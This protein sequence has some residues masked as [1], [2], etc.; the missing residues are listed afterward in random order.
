MASICKRF[1]LYALTILTL[2]FIGTSQSWAQYASGLEGTVV[3]QSG[4]VVTG[5]QCSVINQ[6]TGIRQSASSDTQGYVR[7]LKLP[8]GHYRIEIGAPGFEKWVQRDV[9]VEG[10][11]LRTFYPSLK[12]GQNFATVEVHGE[13]EAL[14]TAQGTVSRTL[15]QQTVSEAPLVGQ[16]VYASVASLA[17]GM[18]GLGDASGSIA[19]AGSQGTNSFVT[20]AGFQINAAG[21]RQDANEFQVDG[22]SVMSTSRDGVVNITPEPDTI[23][24][25]KL[26][27]STFNADEGRQSGA[28]IEVY[29]KPGTNNFHG[30]LSEMHTD[31]AMT[32]RTVFETQVPHSLRNDFGGTLGGPIFKNRTFFFGSLFWMRSLIG[33]TLNETVETQGFEQYVEQN[34]PNSMAAGF[35]KAAPPAA[36]PVKNFLTVA[37]VESQYGSTYAP[38]NIPA[39]MVAEGESIVNASPSNNGFQGHLRIDHNFRGDRD[40]LFYSLFRNTTQAENANIRTVYSY[41]SPDNSFYN[42]VDYLHTFSASLVNDVSAGFV[43]TSGS[44]PA[45][46]PSLPN[47]AWIGGIDATFWQWGPSGWV[48]NNWYAHD[49]LNYTRGAHTFRVGIDVDRQQDMDNFTNGDDRPYFLMLNVLDMA[50]DHPFEQSGPVLNPKTGQVATNLYQRVLLLYTAPY[51]EDDWKINHRLTL[52][53][54]IRFDYFGH[55]STMENGQSPVSF[56]TPGTGSDFA[57]QVANG[58]MVVRGNNGIATNHAQ[59]RFAPRLGFAW[60]VWGNGHTA[61]HGGYGLFNNK[62]GEYGY[63]NNM[64]ENPPN[65]VNPVVSIFTPGETLANMSYGTSSSGA[66]GFAPPPGITFQVD[67]HGGIVGSRISVGG[68]DPNLKSPLVHSWALGVQQKIGG[69]VAE[70]DYFGTA[71]RNLY[72]QTDVNRFA[73]DE[74]INNGNLD[75]LNQSFGEVLYGRNDGIANS[76]LVAFAISKHFSKGWNFHAIYT[77]GKSLDYTSDNDNGVDG[78][79]AEAVLD[80]QTLAGQYG[81]SDYDSRHR[82]SADAVWNAP[83]FHEGVAHA[84]TSGWT[85]T[86]VV[87]LQ[88][89]QPFTVYTG[90][91]Y[92]SGGDYN[93]DGWDFDVPNVPSFGNHISTSRSNFLKGLFPASAFPAPAAGTEGNLGRNTYDGPGFANVNLSAERSFN[94]PVLGDRGKLEL[95]GEFFNLFNR[96]NLTKPVSDL[97]NTLFGYSTSQDSPRFIQLTGHIRF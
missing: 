79:A 93:G 63:V 60:D 39:N 20:E 58:S 64:R 57:A 14:E 81:R 2:A 23:S 30:S 97:S 49:A 68:I 44:Q 32:A 89:G 11:E 19:S 13:N 38:P 86:P 65:D 75:R 43:R 50:A 40:K 95:R 12:I 7:F 88:S 70:G 90:A 25:M 5:A 54:G 45:P 24:E 74:I 55:L 31:A 67:S 61:I 82:F 85:F 84:I 94:L 48:Q 96:V 4:A 34:Y 17:P 1:T 53:A 47:V 80:A 27:S 15:E 87:I 92:S 77:F 8:P 41:L 91:Q 52:N 29:T 18:T 62:I 10:S 51:V 33:E 83:S 69:F 22:T 3:D 46:L 6:D 42:K 71:S 76:D 35:F 26:T 59:Y 37:Q 73:G 36:Y 16:D 72:L 56:F 21:Q 28:L 66:T 9:L 78:T